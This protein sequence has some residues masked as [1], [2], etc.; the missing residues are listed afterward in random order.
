MT[1]T[2][3]LEA[4]FDRD[5]SWSTD[6]TGYVAKPGSGVR[7]SRGIGRDGKPLTSKLS[8]A[9]NN[10]GGEFTVQNSASTFYGLLTPGVPIRI[11]ATVSAVTYTLWTGYAMRWVSSW[12]T[13][14]VSMCQ[15]DCDDL[16]AVMR[17]GEP[18]NITVSTSRD[19]DGALAAIMDA[20]GFDSGDRDFADGVQDLPMHFC[21]GE[22]PIDAMM[23]VAASEMGGLLYPNALGQARF[24]ARNSRLGTT[25][26]ATWGDGTVIIPAAVEYDLNPLEHVTSVTARATVFRT[27]QAETRIFEFSQNMFTRPTATSMALTAGQVW[28]RTFQA[29]SAYVA[30]T[31]PVSVVDYLANDSQDGTGTDRTSLLTVTVTDL[32]GGRFRLRLVNTHSGTIYVTKFQLRGQ[33]VEFYADRAEAVFSLSVPGLPAGRGLQFDVP[34]AGDTGQKLRDYAYQE[35]RVGRYPWPV[36]RLSFVPRTTAEIIAMLSAEIGDRVYY[37]DMDLAVSASARVADWWY[38]EGLSYEI[39]S[40]WAGQTFRITVTLVPAYV[41]RNLDAI[42]FDTFDRADASGDLG[43]SFSGDAWADDSGFDISGGYAVP[44]STGLQVPNLVVA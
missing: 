28:E 1:I 17:D 18:V 2:W 39:P 16:F 26:D 42:A 33:P 40:N 27:G 19:T 13:G 37:A 23:A 32:G 29:N 30:L 11:T 20:L 9:L 43:T 12:R 41:Y 44:N 10:H 5:G 8:V 24:E 3:A 14:T 6:L 34:F 36:L 4:D 35:L 22:N 21:V 25:P 7:I 15:L 31:T 38:V